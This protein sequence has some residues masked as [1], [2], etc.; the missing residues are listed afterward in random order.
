[1]SNYNSAEEK[2]GI[3]L[4]NNSG[5]QTLDWVIRDS[6]SEEVIFKLQYE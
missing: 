5:E 1:M 4:E 3:Q 6:L 2:Q